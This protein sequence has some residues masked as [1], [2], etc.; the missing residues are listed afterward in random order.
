MKLRFELWG[1]LLIATSLSGG[2]ACGGQ[3]HAV[4]DECES[5]VAAYAKHANDGTLSS[6]LHASA[7]QTIMGQLKQCVDALKGQLSA[8]DQKL[9]AATKQLSDAKQDVADLTQKSGHC[10][11][12]LIDTNYQVS[13][14]TKQSDSC[15]VKLTDLDQ[16][17]M[18]RIALENVV[19]SVLGG[20]MNIHNLTLTSAVN[21]SEQYFDKLAEAVATVKSNVDKNTLVIAAIL[22]GLQG[23][24][25]DETKD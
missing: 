2:V 3:G 19:L 6:M 10:H 25:K 4:V 14:L 23:Y 5:A 1:A 21:A 9:S 17:L 16:N 11:E 22:T 24:Q 15:Q 18:D 20:H 12:Q 13:V 8:M 7:H